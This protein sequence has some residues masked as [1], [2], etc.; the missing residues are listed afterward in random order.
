MTA[1]LGLAVAATLAD[2]LLFVA[3]VV[4]GDAIEVNPVV[5]GL[6]PAHAIGARVALLV[7]LVALTL[8][9]SHAG[10]RVLRGV[11]AVVLVTAASAGAI[12]AVATVTA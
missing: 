7:L 12:G 5:A 4:P 3:R 1:L 9:A 6:D 2:V 11:V 8:A 10:S